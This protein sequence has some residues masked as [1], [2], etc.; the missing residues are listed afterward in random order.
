DRLLGEFRLEADRPRID[1][2][3]WRLVGDIE[4]SRNEVRL[5]RR[6]GVDVVPRFDDD[7]DGDLL[8]TSSCMTDGG[9]ADMIGR[10]CEMLVCGIER[11]RPCIHRGRENHADYGRS[12][13]LDHG[14]LEYR[15][16]GESP[17]S[18]DR[19]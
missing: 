12:A 9:D 7:R 3:E 15:S 19:Q 14:F 1:D 13:D 5:G 8:A 18:K 16:T 6:V 4:R 2:G 17:V 11:S 10:I